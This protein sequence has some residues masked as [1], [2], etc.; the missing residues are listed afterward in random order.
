[1]SDD[2]PDCCPGERDDMTGDP[3]GLHSLDCPAYNAWADKMTAA[4][5]ERNRV[6]SRLQELTRRPTVRFVDW[7]VNGDGRYVAD[8]LVDGEDAGYVVVNEAGLRAL[9]GPKRPRRRPS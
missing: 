6:A 2:Q 3:N 4:S 8:V 7:G 5:R 1:M 9:G